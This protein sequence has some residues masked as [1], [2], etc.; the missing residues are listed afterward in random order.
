M[1][2]DYVIHAPDKKSKDYI[3]TRIYFFQT[4]EY[5]DIEIS[6]KNIVGDVIK[7]ILT[8]Y[9]KNNELSSKKPLE[10][11]QYPEAYEIRCVDEDESYFFPMYEV[12]ALDIKEEIGMF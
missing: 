5:L 12:G 9:Q 3:K 4:P 1:I 10:Y 6:Q 8:L 11:P 7:H 2:N